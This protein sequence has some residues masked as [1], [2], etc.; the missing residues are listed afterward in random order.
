MI[1]LLNA[2]VCFHVDEGIEP[3]CIVR[4]RGRDFRQLV[5]EPIP[6]Y[7]D[8]ETVALKNVHGFEVEF[9]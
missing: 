7:T 1:H 8:E 3:L 6:L 4:E 2:D 5:L 9:K